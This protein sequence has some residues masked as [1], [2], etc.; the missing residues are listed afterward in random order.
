[1]CVSNVK[2]H[3]QKGALAKDSLNQALR[4]FPEDKN[5]DLPI[6]KKKAK[7]LD[8][9]SE[10]NL[11]WKGKITLAHRTVASKTKQQ[12]DI[13]DLKAQSLKMIYRMEKTTLKL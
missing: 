8:Q 2:Q 11:A 13:F 4:L 7:L 5:L 10:N 3:S 12:T 1:M 6:G 9:L